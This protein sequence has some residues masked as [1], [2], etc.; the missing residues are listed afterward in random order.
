MTGVQR[1]RAD[2]AT[3]R[4]EMTRVPILVEFLTKV[5]KASDRIRRVC[6]PELPYDGLL[7]CPPKQSMDV[8]D[9]LGI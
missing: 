4:D 7:Q 5:P 3:S 6:G 2:E 8:K 1:N 9:C